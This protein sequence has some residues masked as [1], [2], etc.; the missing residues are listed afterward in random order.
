[1]TSAT[2]TSALALRNTVKPEEIKPILTDVTSYCEYSV[3]RIG[4]E[5]LPAQDKWASALEEVIAGRYRRRQGEY[6]SPH[7]VFSF[8]V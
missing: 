3:L 7:G 8:W 1:V 5:Y 6:H 4:I 2:T